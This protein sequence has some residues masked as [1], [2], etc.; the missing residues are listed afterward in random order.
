MPDREDKC[1]LQES[2]HLFIYFPKNPDPLV[3]RFG[4]FVIYYI[5]V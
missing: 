2:S 3:K 4:T 1:I 5:I